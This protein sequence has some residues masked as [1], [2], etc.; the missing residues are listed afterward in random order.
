[1]FIQS[2]TPSAKGLRHFLNPEP[3]VQRD[4]LHI[5]ELCEQIRGCRAQEVLHLAGVQAHSRERELCGR[6]ARRGERCARFLRSLRVLRRL[7]QHASWPKTARLHANTRAAAA[8][9][10]A[11]SAGCRDLFASSTWPSSTNRS[12]RLG[13]STVALSRLAVALSRSQ[14]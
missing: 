7:T 1:M 14:N 8:L 3:G 12:A 2:Q 13:S 11:A 6:V 5:V 4:S 10:K 9:A